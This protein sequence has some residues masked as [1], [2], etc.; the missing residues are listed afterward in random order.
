M[1]EMTDRSQESGRQREQSALL[2][3]ALSRPGVREVMYVYQSWRQLDE[4]LAAYR[5]AAK[6]P[7]T[8]TTTDH[9]N[10]L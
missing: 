9:A 1:A 8:V 5:S 10:A 7:E 6:R 3:E 2:K 4:G